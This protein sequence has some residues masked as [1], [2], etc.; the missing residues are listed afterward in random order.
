MRL[1]YNYS[2]ALM[3]VY[4]LL[5]NVTFLASV[6]SSNQNYRRH[7]RDALQLVSLV[8]SGRSCPSQ[9]WVRLLNYGNFCGVNNKNKGDPI[10]DVD[11]CCYAHDR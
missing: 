11:F 1:Y 2:A 7:K 9:S 6:S 3:L 8:V 5:L 4:I 10:D